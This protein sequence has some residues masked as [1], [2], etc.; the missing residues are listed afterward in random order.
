MQSCSYKIVKLNTARNALRYIIKAFNIKE[1]YI[2]YYLCPAIRNAVLK[3]QCKINFYHI[4]INFEPLS[5]F[6]DD[7]YILYPN[8]FGV[9]SWI[10]EKLALKYKNLIA[11]N[12]H[13]FFSEPVGIASFNS[14]RKFFTKIKDGAFLYTTKTLDINFPKDTYEYEHKILSYEELCKNENRLDKEDIKIMSACTENYFTSENIDEIK[15]TYI[16]NYE[17]YHKNY[18]SQ[19]RLIFKLKENDVPYKYPYLADTMENAEKTALEFNKNGIIIF[20]YWNNMPDSFTEKEFYTK[21]VAI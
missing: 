3:E 20:R 19:N 12:A 14:V 13:S 4:D 18:C 9:C 21:L 7:A 1:I 16:K 11:D 10:V 15:Q 5:D 8:Y 2:P 17:K 6:P